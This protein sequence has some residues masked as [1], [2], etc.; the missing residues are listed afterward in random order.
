MNQFH[1]L[2]PRDIADALGV[3]EEVV[4]RLA[5]NTSV[6]FNCSRKRLIRGKIRDITPPKHWAKV[7]LRRLHRFFQNHFPGHINAHGGVRGR[8]CFTGAGKHLGRNFVITRDIEK[9]YPSITTE[10]L[11]K[12][13]RKLGFRSDTAVLLARLSTHSG[14]MPQGSPI[15]SDILN[16]FLYNMDQ[17]LSE[18]ESKVCH[19]HR[20]YDDIVVSTDSASEVCGIETLVEQQI[21]QHGLQVSKSKLE[22]NG[23]QSKNVRQLVHGIVV[24]GKPGT[25]ISVESRQCAHIVAENYVRSARCVCPDSIGNVAK[26]RSKLQGYICHFGQAGFSNEPH[27]KKQLEHGDRLV[28]KV[29]ARYNLDCKKWYVNCKSKN[30]PA[31]LARIWKSRLKNAA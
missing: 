18:L 24:S 13:F 21:A 9:C 15:S 8:S 19:F 11:V 25:A 4:W 27:L 3:S 7:Q 17:V 28:E 5:R 30:Q 2:R 20:L 22:L 31:L 23:L 6:M 10:A 14:I 16:I 29:L 26:K 12:Q 1:L